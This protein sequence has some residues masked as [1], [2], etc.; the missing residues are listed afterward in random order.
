MTIEN[1]VDLVRM[2]T[3]DKVRRRPEDYKVEGYPPP[4]APDHIVYAGSYSKITFT[5]PMED[6]EGNKNKH[7]VLILSQTR[8]GSDHPRWW[9]HM[10]DS[11]GYGLVERAFGELGGSFRDFSEE[12]LKRWQE[13]GKAVFEEGIDRLED[14]YWNN[15]ILPEDFF[16]YIR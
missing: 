10:N 8:S 6:F 16:N 9:I 4:I 11:R 2:I 14:L 12:K 13:R 1:G 5:H 15:K 3:I 7:L